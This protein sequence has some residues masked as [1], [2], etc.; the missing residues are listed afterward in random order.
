MLK[1]I[2]KCLLV[3]VVVYAVIVYAAYLR[4]GKFWLPTFGNL[5]S[6]SWFGVSPKL[7]SLEAPAE[8]TWRWRESGRWHYGDSPPP[9]I[10]AERIDSAAGGK[11]NQ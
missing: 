1:F 10:P 5:P 7:Q 2:L 8:P 11:A 9:G 4:T 6:I 3:G